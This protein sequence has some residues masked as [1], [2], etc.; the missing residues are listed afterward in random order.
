L[1]ISVRLLSGRFQILIA[2]AE[3]PVCRHTHRTVIVQR[4]NEDFGGRQLTQYAIHQLLLRFDP[5]RS[6]PAMT[7]P[8]HEQKSIA[9]K[10]TSALPS[11]AVI[12]FYAIES[13]PARQ[14]GLP[15]C[16]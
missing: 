8:G 5:D 11:S 12:T 7:V 13:F 4:G 1:R 6:M 2:F 3:R 10:E 16:R 9:K 14:R 15:E